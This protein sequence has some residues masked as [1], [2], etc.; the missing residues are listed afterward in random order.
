MRQSS[1]T[2]QYTPQ[3]TPDRRV[4]EDD[5]GFGVGSIQ[6]MMTA[7]GNLAMVQL[8]GGGADG[9]V[10]G[11]AA[12]GIQGASGS[13]PHYAA[14]QASF[15][16]HDVS[17][18]KTNVGG[19]GR[20]ACE[21]LGAEAYASGQ[22]VAFAG[23]PSLH[24]AAHEAAHVVQQ[25]A[26]V[27]LPGGVG[28]AGDR[29]ERH[30]DA[31]ADR[32]V[33]GE[34]ASDLLDTMTGGGGGQA[35]QRK[36]KTP[37]QKAAYNNKQAKKWSK[38]EKKL[39]RDAQKGL[40]TVWD[41]ASAECTE[42]H[43]PTLVAAQQAA[44]LGGDGMIGGTSLSA[45]EGFYG[46][47][48]ANVSEADAALDAGK[49]TVAPRPGASALTGGADPAEGG[50]GGGDGAHGTVAAG[51][52]SQGVSASAG[53]RD[54]TQRGDGVTETSDV[55]ANA[56]VTNNGIGLGIGSSNTE[57]V[58]QGDD[59]EV[60]SKTAVGAGV[61]ADKNGTV[62]GNAN[63]AVTGEDGATT[64]VGGGVAY[65]GASGEASATLSGGRS[66]EVDLGRVDADGKP[67]KEEL[68]V[69][70]SLTGGV[71]TK[72]G[73]YNVAAS[74]TLTVGKVSGTVDA[75]VQSG[76]QSPAKQDDG[77][78]KLVGVSSFTAGVGG[79]AKRGR[80]GATIKRTAERKQTVE[81]TFESKAKAE[82]FLKKNKDPDEFMSGKQSVED[83]AVGQTQTDGESD[84]TA[85]GGSMTFMGVLEVGATMVWGDN[86]IVEVQ[87]AT[88]SSVVVKYTVSDDVALGGNAGTPIISMGGQVSASDFSVTTVEFDITTEGGKES[89]AT[90]RETGELTGDKGKD[91]KVVSTTTG[92]A[93]VNSFS[94]GIAGLDYGDASTVTSSTTTLADG[95]E[96][97]ADDG[98][99]DTSLNFGGLYQNSESYGFTGVEATKTD[100]STE[101]HYVGRGK[102]KISSR[103]DTGTALERLVGGGIRHQQDDE[104]YKE[105]WAIARK[106]SD[107]DFNTFVRKLKSKDWGAG[108]G[109]AD[110]ARTLREAV[111][112]DSSNDA[113]REAFAEFISE[114]GVYGWTFFE[115]VLKSSGGQYGSSEASL[116]DY[117][118][119]MKGSEV[120]AG[121]AG[122]A[123][124][125]KKIAHLQKIVGAGPPE[126]SESTLSAI[127]ELGTK[128]VIPKLEAIRDEKKFAEVP[129]KLREHE[130]ARVEEQKAT[131]EQL[132]R[133]A[134]ETLNPTAHANHRT[135]YDA[136]TSEQR[137][138]VIRLGF[139]RASW[140]GG[141]RSPKFGGVPFAEL[142][143]GVQ[144]AVKKLH[145]DAARWDEE[146]GVGGSTAAGAPGKAKSPADRLAELAIQHHTEAMDSLRA[147]ESNSRDWRDDHLE[148]SK[149]V[150][151]DG[152]GR[153]ALY[154]QDKGFRHTT[155]V[156]S[157]DEERYG[158]DEWLRN[159]GNKKWWRP[160]IKAKQAADVTS[161]DPAVLQPATKKAWESAKG[162]TYSMRKWVE[163]SS[164]LWKIKKANDRDHRA[165]F[166]G[167]ASI[168]ERDYGQGLQEFEAER[169]A[170]EAAQ[171]RQ[172]GELEAIGADGE[173]EKKKDTDDER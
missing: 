171:K 88:E 22:S 138:A 122:H 113:A 115:R 12:Q 82:A 28:A 81:L 1:S 155:H 152:R 90:F 162:W 83:M 16:D 145:Y 98:Q 40:G 146:N 21:A 56:S 109:A 44:G 24:T 121:R 128:T 27:S 85:L 10:H 31:V 139:K 96:V 169:G 99:R 93:A 84:Q 107:E 160:A 105:E 41:P 170:Q 163:A 92:E 25:R 29:Y 70:G 67:V 108:I 130:A 33:A 9:D 5:G 136:L 133:S 135:P 42:A 62:G 18:V 75:S 153:G 54:A 91:Y 66:K 79:G 55:S 38:Q 46:M 63:V 20:Q 45:L 167:Y 159:R 8:S 151:Y 71:N 95:T 127:R 52:T 131:L 15:G 111:L 73:A 168:T 123:K 64:S 78:W 13:L 103:N 101:H 134:F 76:W 149:A 102:V 100:G 106:V 6:A 19:A 126:L 89:L 26:G 80:A 51:A 30:A 120:W 47:E 141:E 110:E 60:K 72:T 156:S 68:G 116:E 150:H 172:A 143:P 86:T 147:A 137:N 119:T 144:D 3:T 164:Q 165:Y 57:T 124:I 53:V 34:S 65:N 39:V 161:R 157:K 32:V 132:E 59:Q 43:I 140:N 69:S 158:H 35:V 17:G 166:E 77:S 23:Q 61:T 129:I 50:R 94:A 74:G 154:S 48:T 104:K 49:T 114:T 87:K 142:H 11:V 173:V 2:R 4:E 37:A 117:D 148:P 125:D 118:I 97:E 7:A 112:A 58:G 36:A 14:I